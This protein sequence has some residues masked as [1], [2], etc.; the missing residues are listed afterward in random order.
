MWKY[1]IGFLAGVYVAQQYGEHVPD[2]AAVANGI[3]I[4]LKK[5]LD[6]YSKSRK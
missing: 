5:K 1:A 2:V 4:D 6:E 3:K